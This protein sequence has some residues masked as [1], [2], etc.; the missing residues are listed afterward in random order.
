MSGTANRSL[1][2]SGTAS[3]ARCVAVRADGGNGAQ[4]GL[5]AGTKVRVKSEVRVYHAPK[6]ADGLD[7]QGKEGVIAANTIYY[8]DKVLS[9]NL[10]YKVQFALD[11]EGAPKKFFAH[12]VSGV[13]GVVSLLR[14]CGSAWPRALNWRLP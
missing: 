7:L 10:P 3:R 1:C 6:K 12:L 11:Y 2:V 9:P 4:E 13:R 8:K 5:A 14:G